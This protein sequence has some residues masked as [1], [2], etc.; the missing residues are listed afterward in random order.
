MPFSADDYL[1]YVDGK[2]RVDGVRSFIDSRGIALPEGTTDD[3]PGSRLRERPRQRQERS[4]P[5]VLRR[6]GIEPY[7]GSVRLLDALDRLGK[8]VAVVSSSR[9]ASEVLDAA[10]LADRF[11]VVVDGNVAAAATSPASRPRTR[12]SPPPRSSVFRRIAAPSSRTPSPASPPAA[13][14]ASPS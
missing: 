8:A 9:N 6:D 7:P 5:E 10:G 3:E 12:S 14:A 11:D 13:P 2:R 4:V 1:A